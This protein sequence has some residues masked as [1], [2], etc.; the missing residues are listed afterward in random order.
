LSGFRLCSR[1]VERRSEKVAKRLSPSSSPPPFARPYLLPVV[2]GPRRCWLVVY[3]FVLP[4]RPFLRTF[5][6]FFFVISGVAP[7]PPPLPVP[8][9]RVNVSPS[10]PPVESTTHRFAGLVLH[11]FVLVGGC[12]LFFSSSSPAPLLLMVR[13]RIFCI[14]PDGRRL[15][16]L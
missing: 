5:R 15:P 9:S 1:S 10:S 3:G 12:F 14:P 4:P 2:G 16:S 8:C 6:F 11:S 7:Y 13:W